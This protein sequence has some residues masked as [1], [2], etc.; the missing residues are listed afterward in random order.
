MS[1]IKPL[2]IKWSVFKF[3]DIIGGHLV[4]F[5]KLDKNFNGQLPFLCFILRIGVLFDI[6]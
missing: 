5:C 2:A 1:K 6:Q 4:K 3:K